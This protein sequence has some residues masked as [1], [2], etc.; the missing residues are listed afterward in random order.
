M[1]VPKLPGI[2]V[3]A[4]TY[5]RP[6][7]LLRLL[8]CL[9]KQRFINFSFIDV[10]VVNDGSDVEYPL[11]HK[12]YPFKFNY[13]FKERRSDKMPAVYRA[14]NEAFKMGDKEVI[15]LLGDDMVIH[16]SMLFTTQLYHAFNPRL[17]LMSHIS[18]V[19]M[20]RLYRWAPFPILGPAN[21]VGA[22]SA[23][24]WALEQIGGFEEDFDGSMGYADME[25]GFRL[26]NLGLDMWL[27]AGITVHIDDSETGSWRD[28]F[29]KKWR[30]EEPGRED[31]NYRIL[32][33][34]YPNL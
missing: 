9:A 30:E 34:K 32:L 7:S 1:D 4:A 15:L 33:E 5:N 11:D 2:S 8:Y 12:K 31:R 3:V 27:G 20:E 29:V 10:S 16:E 24:R 21:V 19:A 28:F 17:I 14:W 13:K 23:P 25:L 26:K 22:F 18:N 6:K